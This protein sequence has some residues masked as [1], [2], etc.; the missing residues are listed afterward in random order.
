MFNK[1]LLMN[2]NDKWD[3]RWSSYINLG[4]NYGSMYNI[5]DRLVSINTENQYPI[6]NT[7]SSDDNNY[8]IMDV[9]SFDEDDMWSTGFTE[10]LFGW[11]L[12][13]AQLYITMDGNSFPGSF[14]DLANVGT[15]GNGQGNVA[16][17]NP[18]YNDPGDGSPCYRTFYC[19]EL[20]AIACF[21]NAESFVER[22]IDPILENAINLENGLGQ[23]LL[24]IKSFINSAP[25]YSAP[26][27]EDNDEVGH[28]LM[29]MLSKF[30]FQYEKHSTSKGTKIELIFDELEES[31]KVSFELDRTEDYYT[32]SLNEISDFDTYSNIM[33][34]ITENFNNIESD[35][36]AT[37]NIH[38]NIYGK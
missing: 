8:L 30:S 23:F 21:G 34:L 16:S 12:I 18:G 1:K 3:L 6:V 37:E 24:L 4:E 38:I 17:S 27:Y 35:P 26:I 31:P 5:L 29:H 25:S 2:D 13:I 22:Y 10:T 14:V 11:I 33:N 36:D 32:D 19:F 15:I 9:L 20:L 7:P 28:A